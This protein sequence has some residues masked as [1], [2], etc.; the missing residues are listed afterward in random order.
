MHTPL[1]L[2]RFD[3]ARLRAVLTT[4]VQARHC[5]RSEALVAACRLGTGPA[6]GH[7]AAPFGPVRIELPFACYQVD[8][9]EIAR[10]ACLL[11]DGSWRMVDA[12]SAAGRLAIRA[13]A[14]WCDAAWWRARQVADAWDA[15]LV[16][17]LEAL[18]GF[19]PRRTT[20]IVIEGEP[21][22]ACRRA[23][24]DLER[25]AHAWR[26]AVRVLLVGAPM[27]TARHIAL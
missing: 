14:L 16:P 5:A 4:A 20:L 9:A 25:R 12:S 24:A 17:D 2:A 13:R 21:G 3:A 7:W 10:R 11:L 18:I 1:P 19:T 6:A 27:G 26:R 23:L 22:D 15:G 8:D